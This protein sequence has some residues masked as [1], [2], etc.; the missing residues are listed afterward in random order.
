MMKN[1]A[2]LT[3]IIQREGDGFVALCPELDVASQ[4]TT[5][6]EVRANLNEAVLLF[7][8]TASPAELRDRLHNETYISYLDIAVA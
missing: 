5:V 7:L 1:P 6:E 3:A 4:G 8:E 2:Q